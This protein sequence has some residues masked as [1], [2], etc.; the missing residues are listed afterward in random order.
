MEPGRSGVV[1]QPGT[2]LYTGATGGG[3]TPINITLASQQ[4]IN[5][6]NTIRVFMN[7]RQSDQRGIIYPRPVSLNNGQGLQELLLDEPRG[8]V[9]VT[10]SGFNRIDVFDIKKQAFVS[11]IEVGQLPRSMAMTLDGGTLYVGNQGGESISVVDLDAQQVVGN[12]DFPPIP[13]AGN[14]N[15]IQPTALAMS[16]SG[17]QFIMSNGTFWHLI[18]NQA[19]PRLANPV[20]PTS[21]P[22]PQYMTASPGGDFILTVS[23]T[24]NGY[25]YDGLADTYTT[26]SQLYNQTPVSYFG[27]IAAAPQGSYFVVSGLTVNNALAV[28]GGV[29]RPGTTQ[30][31]FGAP[32]QPPIQT[33]VSAGQRN[34]A[35]VYPIDENTFIRLTT[36]VRQNTTSVTR[37]DSRPTLELVDIRTGAGSVVGVAP[38]NPVSSVFGTARVN[39]PSRQLVVDSK[40]TAYSITLSGLSVIPL[41]TSGVSPRPSVTAGVR[42]IVNSS[43][44]TPNFKPGE[45]ITVNGTNLA[46]AASADTVPLPTVLGGTCV[47]FDDVPLPLL[48]T[49]SGQISAQLPPTVR[50]GQNV[51]QVRSLATA[52]SSDPFVVTVQ[53]P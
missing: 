12:V 35:A 1:R 36:P 2:N 16:L 49:S 11:P 13:R 33:I 32:G 29:E 3:G 45:F 28:I 43:D 46:T 5:F 25:L 23:G 44:G 27:P 51:V 34:V 17:L 19:T 18:G 22:G 10:N 14:Q 37:D 6:P 8:K 30:F 20:T 38:D 40:G 31:I 26:S 39:V 50:P 48:Q 42:G 4:A 53:K 24:G 52:Q 21:I 15:S 7:Y 9:Y 47:V 41:A